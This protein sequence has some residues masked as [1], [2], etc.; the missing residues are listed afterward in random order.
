MSSIYL[1]KLYKKKKFPVVIFRL[2]L[3]YGPGQNI[4][5][6]LPIIINGCLGNKIFPTSH[7]RQLRDF[8]Y[9]D[10]VIDAIIKSLRYKSSIGKILN[11]GSGKPKKLIE[12]INQIIKICKGGKAEFGKVLIR[13]DEILNL[14]P[15]IKETKKI[16]NWKLKTN[17][18]EG[19]IRTI[20]FYKKHKLKI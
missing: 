17:F 2:Y 5:R 19:L 14:Y 16:L 8:I 10:D 1:S 6:F 7:G 15:N 12:V 4:N 13:K 18:T 20:N 9:I 11:L 3:A